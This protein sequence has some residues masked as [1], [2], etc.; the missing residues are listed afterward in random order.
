MSAGMVVHAITVT[1][2]WSPSE[3][4]SYR[5]LL[6]QINGAWKVYDIDFGKDGLLTDQLK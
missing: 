3:Q 4:R 5:V 1:L 6:Q 2:T